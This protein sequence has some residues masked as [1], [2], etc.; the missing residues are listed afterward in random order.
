MIEKYKYILKIKVTKIIFI[1]YY[2]ETI[3]FDYNE[4]T[5]LLQILFKVL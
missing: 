2:T 4:F 1:S 5:F 3:E